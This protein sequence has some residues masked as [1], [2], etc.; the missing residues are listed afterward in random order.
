MFAQMMA[1]MKRAEKQASAA[2][3]IV[4]DDQYDNDEDRLQARVS[5]C[6]PA[7]PLERWFHG[8]SLPTCR[9]TR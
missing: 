3:G 1:S 8:S 6:A 4:D 7:L 2:S 9:E 5:T